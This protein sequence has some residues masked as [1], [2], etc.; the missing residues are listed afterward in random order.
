MSI[1]TFITTLGISL[2]LVFVVV[3]LGIIDDEDN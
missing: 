2:G 1:F 3:W